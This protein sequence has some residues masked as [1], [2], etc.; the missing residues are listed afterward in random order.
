[1]LFMPGVVGH[2]NGYYILGICKQFRRE[3]GW[4]T[5]IYNKRGFGGMPIK[6]KRLIGYELTEDFR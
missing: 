2:S 6:G 1:M 3:M 5:A 4:R